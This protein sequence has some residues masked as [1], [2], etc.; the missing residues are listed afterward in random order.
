MS[1]PVVLV[2]GA[3][4]AGLAAA[5][6]LRR[7]GIPATLLERCDVVACAW[8]QRYD[9]LRL[10]TCRWTSK[11]P[12]TPYP[13]RTE[14]FPSR[15][16]VVSYLT[17]YATQN[18]LDIRFGIC[19]ERIDPASDG[20]M[21]HTSRGEQA[22]RHVVIAT[23]HQHTPLIPEWPG[24]ERYTGH[25]VHSA[26]Y[27]NSRD[28][29]DADVLVVGPGS[30]GMEIAYDAAEGGARRVWISVRTP[31]NITL[32]Q[33]GG[34][35][36]DLSARVLMRLPA[37]TADR[38]A[39]LVQRL[40]IGDL[41]K[42]GLRPPTEGVFA[43]NQREGKVPTTVDKEVIHAI[44][45]G[46]IEIVA[47]VQSFDVDA[48]LLADG[49]RLAPGAIIAATGYS[50]GLEP[51]VG[52]L[53]VLDKRGVPRVHGGPAVAPGLRFIGYKPTA[54]QIGDLG[55]EARRVAEGIRNDASWRVTSS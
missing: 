18:Q 40:A 8:R 55:R 10:N 36:G 27:R 31:P 25:L 38:L 20:W 5:A 21:L 53:N 6:E 12:N 47:A 43:R 45:A 49:T 19:L 44:K 52:H 22:A 1:K 7:L 35:P 17:N 46:R 13:R 16:E 28:L 41:S 42:W 33:S 29:R 26:Y 14:L 4:P 2:V 24:S 32:R 3:G 11:L 48:V 34:L 9:R 15:D 50:T 39:H 37:P 23:G 30:S 54:G 51:L